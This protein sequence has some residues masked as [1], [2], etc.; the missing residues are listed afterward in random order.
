VLNVGKSLVIKYNDT[1][2]NKLNVKP[3][4]KKDKLTLK[5]VKLIKEY[6]F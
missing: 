6:Y 3:F 4:P 2:K 5:R 1:P